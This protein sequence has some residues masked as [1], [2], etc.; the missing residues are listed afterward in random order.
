KV[1]ITVLDENDNSPQFDITSDSAVNVAEDSAIGRRIAVVLARDPDAGSNG[2]V[3]FSLTSGNIGTVFEIRTTNNTYGEVFVGRPLDRELL[4]HYTLKIQASD[5]G[6]PPR[7][8]EHTLRV[9]ILDVNDNPPIIGNPFGY[10]VSVNENV[11]GG[12]AVAQ[13][14]ATDRDVGL[15]SVLSYY[16]T[17]GNEDLI[18]RMDR[19]TGEIATRPSPPDREQQKFYRLVVTVEDEGN[20]SLS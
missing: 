15:N 16:I 17:Q 4:D 2:Q 19:V 13:V 14:R 12:S 1:T 18:F 7:R 3:T 6:V 11:G 10:N 20:P 5:S 9:N 8:K